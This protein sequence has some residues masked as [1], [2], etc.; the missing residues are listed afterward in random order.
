[1]AIENRYT[2]MLQ[3][4]PSRPLKVLDVGCGEGAFS[5][6]I[7]RQGHQVV[8]IDPSPAALAAAESLTSDQ[9]QTLALRFDGANIESFPAHSFDL[10][11]STQV[12][13]HTHN[14]GAVLAQ[15]NR[16][17]RPSGLLLL[18]IPNSATPRHFLRPVLRR[19]SMIERLRRVNDS[20]LHRYDK[21]SDHIQAW[22]AEHFVRLV[23]TAGFRLCD[24]AA[25]EGVPLPWEFSR[26]RMPAYVPLPGV[27]RDWAY[28]LA[29][30][31]TKS[32]EATIR[33]TD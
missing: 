16:V 6:R 19:G 5:Q 29:F 9:R 28:T 4:L 24:Y 27:F 11:V 33:T 2:G 25:L 20:A 21:S 1:M 3:M 14:P 15:M 31:F 32:C 13:E 7:A 22:D 12:L 26:I 17:L 8:G 23:G 30:M 18:S 10:V